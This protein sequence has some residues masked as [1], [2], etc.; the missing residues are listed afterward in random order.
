MSEHQIIA[1][2]AID[3]PVSE[4]N[5]AYMERQSS[6]AEIT[7]WSFDN[8]YHY[9][10]FRGNALEMLRRGYDMH[11]HYANYGI[12]TLLIRL[13]HGLPDPQAAKPYLG[14][15]SV[16]YTPDKKGP[17]GTLSIEPQH[18]PDD[19]EEI[20]ELDGLLERLL[21]LRAEILA[22]DLRP[23]YLAHLAVA[24]DGAHDPDETVEG[25]VPGG[26]NKLTRAQRALA[27]MYGLDDSLLAAVAEGCP[28]P[29]V[30]GDPGNLHAAWLARQPESR[31]DQWLAQWLA[32]PQTTA[33]GEML[34]E[35]RQTQAAALWPTVRKDRTIAELMAA[36]ETIER[37]ARLKTDASAAKKRAK[38]LAGMAADPVPTLRKTEE[39]AAE[40]NTDA[41]GQI[42]TL[43]AELREA[44]AGSK[45]E[46]L[47]EVQAKKLKAKHPTLRFLVSEL[48][49]QGFLPK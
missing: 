21:P 33:R 48:R 35:F 23:L 45:Q 42:A 29:P 38:R 8:E 14:T 41:Y 27:E 36:A 24:C 30:P 47:A 17:G 19:L 16:S 13:P 43:L 11:V 5:L 9:G 3:G 26:L 7:P 31:K 18:D 39:L 44:L 25:P 4:K 2:R 40:R 15:D 10:N 1:F 32:D 34:A 20:W 46:G 37:D 6:R 28:V 12:R 22:G 49:K